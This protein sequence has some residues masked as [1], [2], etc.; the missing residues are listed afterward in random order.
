MTSSIYGLC[1]KLDM[2]DNYP[3]IIKDEE[4]RTI[5]FVNMNMPEDEIIKDF[6]RESGTG[7]S[8][9][10]VKMTE[11]DDNY[12]FRITKEWSIQ[13]GRLSSKKRN[14]APNLEWILDEMKKQEGGARAGKLMSNLL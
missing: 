5:Y 3:R 11:I 6:I 4:R 7:Y 1:R 10:K 2:V 14:S 12:S 9:V 13:G 8:V